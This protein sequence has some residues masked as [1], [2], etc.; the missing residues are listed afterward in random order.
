MA[1]NNPVPTFSKADFNDIKKSL[2]DFLRQKPDFQD[3]DFEGSGWNYL[4]DLL[5]YNTAYNAFHLNMVGNEMFLDSA[6]LRG[7]IVSKAKML[8]YLPESI[9]SARAQ[10]S[11]EFSWEETKPIPQ[12]IFIPRNAAFM[13]T[14]TNNQRYQFV[15]DKS[16]ILYLL[17]PSGE[18]SDYDPE[19]KKFRKEINVIEGVRL[20]HRFTVSPDPDQTF[21]LPNE[22]VDVTTV[23]VWIQ[24]SATNAALTPFSLATDITELESDSNVFYL[25]YNEDNL[26]E[27]YF[28][29]GVISAGFK[30]DSQGNLIT[31]GI[32]PG[33][34]VVVEYIVSEGGTN[35]NDVKLFS[36][37]NKIGIA[38][39]VTSEILSERITTVTPSYGGRD[40]ESDKSIKYYA[41]V[42]YEM[43]NRAVTELDFERYVSKNYPYIDSIAVW[44]GEENIP[45][46]YG[47]V[48]ISIKPSQGYV[49]NNEDKDIIV[50]E[51]IRPRCVVTQD[52]IIVDPDYLYLL[53][54]SSVK[55]SF[56]DSTKTVNDIQ[57]AVYQTIEDF[58]KN[59]LEKFGRGFAYSDFVCA[60]DD[61]DPGI[62]SNITSI[63]LKKIIYPTI[64]LEEGYSI[65][66]ANT[67]DNL[68][69]KKNLY[70]KAIYSSPFYYLRR[71]LPCIFAEDS[72]GST[73]LSIFQVEVG[74]SLTK[75]REMGTINPVSGE[76]IIEE[77]FTPRAWVSDMNRIEFYVTPKEYDINS[78][79]NLILVINGNDIKVK[80]EHK[81]L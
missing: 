10:L 33:N 5:S 75:L 26:L 65:Q 31:N 76:I 58:S 73:I 57:Y 40:P 28:G 66:F 71:D 15:V 70:Q 41:P 42:N 24:E 6:I 13:G 11:I 37:T 48:F 81:Y 1:K 19:T 45:V 27:L 34:I 62:F 54:N 46:Q 59:L 64:G 80:V 53:V 32:E 61:T 44:G 4:I 79:R 39:P 67:I 43:Q 3:F 14:G 52:P 9:T 74:G 63:H 2:K 68:D 50:N 51:I 16:Y 8:G 49:L 77:N 7:S 35:A 18:P 21:V 12:Q 20:S 60:I 78:A 36:P 47:R 72:I 29:D 23:R 22:N 69:I 55:F 17:N 25:Q 30:S 38:S 56:R